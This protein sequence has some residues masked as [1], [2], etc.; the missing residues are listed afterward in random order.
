MFESVDFLIKQFLDYLPQWT[1]IYIA[2]GVIG[3]IVFSK[4]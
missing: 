1:L 2:L 4:K 3:S